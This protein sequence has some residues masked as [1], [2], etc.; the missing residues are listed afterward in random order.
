M[1]AHIYGTH[2]PVEEPS[3][4]SKGDI[5]SSIQ[6]PS[7]AVANGICGKIRPSAVAVL[8]LVTS[9]YFVDAL[10]RQVAAGRVL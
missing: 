9:T 1:S 2:V 6:L 10:H 5:G 8:R 3:T 4:A 7:S